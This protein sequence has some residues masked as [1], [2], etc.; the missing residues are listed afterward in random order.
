MKKFLGLLSLLLLCN[1]TRADVVNYPLFL[2]NSVDPNVLFNLSIETPM[3]GAAYNDEAGTLSGGSTCSGRMSGTNYGRC[4]FPTETYLGYFDSEKCYSY[5]SSDN[6]FDPTSAV[7]NT[8]R[9]CSGKFSGNFMN[10]ATMTS[11][12]MFIMT[13]TGGNRLIDESSGSN[14]KTVIKKAK[15]TG[16][17]HKKY[18]S[19]TENT[20]PYKVTPHNYS[21]LVIEYSGASVIFK[22][23]TFNQSYN[24]NVRVCNANISGLG[25]NGL[26]ENCDKYSDPVNGD[27]Y[28]PQGLIQKNA[29]NMRFAA[30]SFARDNSKSR[31]GGVL[32]SNMKY[33]GIQMPDALG[34]SSDNPNKEYTDKGTFIQFPD[35]RSDNT[36]YSH[37]QYTGIINYINRFNEFGYKSYDPASE[38]FYESIR[39][40]KNLGPT[41]DYYTGINPADEPFPVIT[42]WQDPIQ[43]SCQKNFI[44]GMNDAYSW[45]DKRL[46]G[47]YFTQETMGT[48]N[49]TNQ[50]YGAPTNAD[51]DIN[52]TA[53]TD[54]VGSIEG[55]TSLSCANGTK[56]LGKCAYT[57]RHASFYIAGLAHYANT[58]DIR[59][60]IE[61]KQTISSF[62]IDSQEY[63]NNPSTGNTNMLWLAGKYGGYIDEDGDG[64]PKN[65]DGT[66][67]EWDADGDG[68]PDNYVLASNPQRIVSGL[69]DAFRHIIERSASGGGVSMSNS[70]LQTDSLLFQ[71]T[72]SNESWD[73]D[74]KAYIIDDG[75]T[76]DNEKWRATDG[77]PAQQL[78]NIL[79]Y[80]GDNGIEFKHGQLSNSQ[81]IQLSEDQLNYLRGEQSKELNN[82]GSFRNRS[83]KIGDI[84]H[85]SPVVDHQYNYGFSS[86]PSSEGSTYNSYRSS[87][88]YINRPKMLYIGANDGMIHGINTDNGEEVFSYVPGS[89]LTELAEL[90]DPA[91]QHR[92]Y[93][94]GQISL[95]DAYFNSSWKSV[96]IGS[97]GR[98]GSSMFALDVSNP[99]NISS[100]DVLWEISA[101]DSD[102]SD[103]G[104]QLGSAK[105]VRLNNGKWAALFGNG[106]QKDSP[107]ANPNAKAVLYIVDL[108]TGDLIKKI[109]PPTSGIN[110]LSEISIVDKDSDH[111]IDYVY[112]GDLQGNLWKFDLSSTVINDWAIANQ[113]TSLNPV[114]LFKASY[115][116]TDGNGQNITIAQPITVAPTITKHHVKGYVLLFG[117]GKYFAAQDNKLLSGDPVNSFYG[118][119]DDL[120]QVAGSRAYLLEQKILYENNDPNIE[121][122]RITSNNTLDYSQKNGWYMDLKN[123]IT[124]SANGEK[125]ILQA[126]F[127]QEKVIFFTVVPTSDPCQTGGI[128]WTMILNAIDCRAGDTAFTDEN[129][130]GVIDDKDKI[131]ITDAQGNETA[132]IRVGFKQDRMIT[133]GIIVKNSNGQTILITNNSEGEVI[134]TDLATD[135]PDTGRL[136]WQQIR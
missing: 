114:P 31:N 4:Y 3:G 68:M 46:P 67:R 127:Y 134:A 123:I 130:D 57:S 18:I 91:Y 84:I 28:K 136:S 115:D 27:Y 6:Y 117:T 15:A 50:D 1:M 71:S 100:S 93:V 64:T 14:A 33:V 61:D 121:P 83:S 79:S 59:S 8:N 51:P 99:N 55:I 36:T 128:S 34:V 95:A 76:L 125:V 48:F 39:Y 132:F 62:I 66:N 88:L 19:G 124:N 77:I 38:L 40:F 75:V 63:S 96:L 20:A 41:P 82:G 2:S 94:D 44:I 111:K 106:Y 17:F 37:N 118:I 30:T 54:A 105:I 10:W 103:L 80:D 5:S 110:G 131:I 97:R 21:H 49:V 109:T 112:A 9:E 116:T 104:V 43:H 23:G 107:S 78:R 32:R 24:V 65:V 47:T 35:S 135:S 70:K 56:T 29:S 101:S 69:A 120:S 7:I 98:G 113:D 89:F 58:Q 119:H 122:Y 60:D 12:D 81:K 16:F 42:N 52:V 11:I 92:F 25:L 22:N 13:T 86:L 133:G 72:F 108:E 26:E 102:F 53:L 85:S 90:T 45:L 126:L 74:L 129:N 87:S 73:G